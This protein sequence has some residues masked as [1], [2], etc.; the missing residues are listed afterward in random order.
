[1]LLIWLAFCVVDGNKH[2]V[3]STPDSFLT[4]IITGKVNALSSESISNDL[5]EIVTRFY[6]NRFLFFFSEYEKNKYKL[7]LGGK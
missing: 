2:T 3:Y 4:F 5:F 6:T 1:M 7:I